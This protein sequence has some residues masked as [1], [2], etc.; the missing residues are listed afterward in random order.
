MTLCQTRYPSKARRPS[1]WRVFFDSRSSQPGL[2][3][4]PHSLWAMDSRPSEKKKSVRLSWILSASHCSRGSRGAGV[5]TCDARSETE[6]DGWPRWWGQG[7]S[8]VVAFFFRRPLQSRMM[9]Q[10]SMSIRSNESAIEA[11]FPASPWS[12]A[13]R[14]RIFQQGC[15]LQVRINFTKVVQD[16]RRRGIIHS[17]SKDPVTVRCCMVSSPAAEHWELWAMGLPI[18]N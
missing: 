13:V 5:E 9:L 1:K 17:D 4:Q 2:H 10:K 6:M 8:I 15:S 18:D 11:T 12:R 14:G 3:K 7:L 16:D